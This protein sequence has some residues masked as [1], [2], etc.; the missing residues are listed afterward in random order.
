MLGRHYAHDDLRAFK[1]G[2]EI[3]AGR[4]GV[5]DGAARKKFFVEPLLHDRLADVGLMGPEANAVR[6]FAS[7]HNGNACAP[8]SGADNGDLTHACFDPKRFSVPAR[9]RRRLAWCLTMMSTEAVA[10]NTRAT[11]LWPS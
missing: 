11:A 2:G 8:R 6:P 1:G 5:G 4:D 9:R 10:I 7:E 3:I